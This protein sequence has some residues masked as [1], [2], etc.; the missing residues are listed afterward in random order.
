VLAL[1]VA[2]SN[3]DPIVRV[4]CANL[5]TERLSKARANKNLYEAYGTFFA[6]VEAIFHRAIEVHRGFG[7]GQRDC[8]VSELEL[9]RQ[10]F[11]EASAVASWMFINMMELNV[12][13]FSRNPEELLRAQNSLSSGF[14]AAE[15]K[16]ARVAYAHFMIGIDRALTA[17]EKLALSHPRLVEALARIRSIE[18]VTIWPLWQKYQNHPSWVEN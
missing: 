11:T 3:T 12:D 15:R 5:L 14:D 18:Q 4:Q 17:D 8:E 10:A 13:Y 1:N 9:L 6:D 7:A 16:N 2:G